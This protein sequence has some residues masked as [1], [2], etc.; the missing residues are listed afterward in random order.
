MNDYDAHQ[1]FCEVCVREMEAV[2]SGQAP[3]HTAVEPL[4][5]PRLVNVAFQPP[6]PVGSSAVGVPG[7]RLQVRIDTSGQALVIGAADTLNATMMNIESA[8]TSTRFGCTT[9]WWRLV[10]CLG[11]RFRPG[12]TTNRLSTTQSFDIQPQR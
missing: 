4:P 10:C 9:N 6:A 7:V 1:G 8:T 2:L 5:R 11:I 12:F 3:I